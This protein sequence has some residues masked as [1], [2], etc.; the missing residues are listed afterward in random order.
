MKTARR[1][2]SERE[3]ADRDVHR[4]D[5][6]HSRQA[7][8]S[9]TLATAKYGTHAAFVMIPNAP[10]PK[11]QPATPMQRIHCTSELVASPRS[12]LLGRIH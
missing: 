1:G 3:S 2:N 6:R 8:G 9:L 5:P 12:G 11:K 4:A 10:C 7:Q